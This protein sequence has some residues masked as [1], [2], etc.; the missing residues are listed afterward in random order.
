MARDSMPDFFS[1]LIERVRGVP[2]VDAAAVSNCT[3]LNGGCNGT[4]MVRLDRPKPEKG[5]A[6]IVGIHWA[7]PTWFST[8]RV[9]IKRGRVF[10]NA[11]RANAPKVVVINDVAASTLFP[12]EDP[13]GKH[14]EL[15]QGGIDDGTIVGVVGSVR[16][17]ADSAPKAET[18]ISYLQAPRAGMIVYVRTT[19]DPATIGPE[20]R[21]AVQEIAPT[22]P[23]YDMQTMDA[24]T[25]AATGRQRFSASLLAL[26]AATA[27]SLAA[28]G[29]YGVMSLAVSAR[30]RE[31]G[32][33]IALGAD[34]R[35]VQ[36]LVIGEGLSLA[37]AGAFF[38]I[39]AALFATPVLRTM[40]Y[41]LA[42]SDPATYVGVAVV[43]ATTAIIAS[44]IPARRAARVDPV[45]ALRAD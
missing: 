22:F 34:Q 27:L 25:A 28:I 2:G 20:I 30:T 43:L 21:H 5:L 16:Q 32:I 12:G 4:G 11:D 37:S 13:I 8:L 19:R 18:Y 35:R 39:A 38:G 15:G 40:L 45:D 3:P 17:K 23:I 44:W 7:S 42:P 26:F 31:I 10:T 1:Q 41:D 29:I 6:P 9:P 33:R 24:R 14:V 36:R